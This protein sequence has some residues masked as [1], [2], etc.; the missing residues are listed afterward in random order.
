MKLAALIGLATSIG[1]A[2]AGDEL[3]VG[4]TSQAVINGT[5]ANNLYTGVGQLHGGGC[6]AVLVAPR[7]MLTSAHCLQDHALGCTTLAA[8]PMN[9]VFAQANGGWSGEAS[10]LART[11]AIEGFA[12]RP[13]LFDLG[14]CEVSDT[15]HCGPSLRENIDHSKELVVLY[16][17]DEAPADAVPLPIMVHPNVDTTHFA[18]EVGK[19]SGLPTWVDDNE[20]VV[21]TVGYGVGSHAY[22]VDG[23][24]VRGRD[25][26][27]QRW[28]A[29]ST[30]FA[31]YLGASDCNS[32]QPWST[33][34]GVVVAPDDLSP[35]QVG[36]A[37]LVAAGA[38]FAG[39]DF[40]HSGG[41]DSGGPILVGKGSASNGVSPTALPPPSASSSYD[42]NRSYIAGTASLWVGTATE[43]RT[44]FTPT[45]TLAAGTFLKQ[46]LH[47][48]D[49]D[50][51]ADAVDDDTDN[52]G[53]DDDADQH[54]SDRWVPIG[55]VHHL[56]CRPHSS[57]WLGDEG[58]DSDGDGLLN[59]ED[60]NDDNDAFLDGP[61]DCPVHTSGLCYRVGETCP[62]EPLFFDCRLG[63]C[64][65]LLVRISSVINPDP[66]RTWSY[67]VRSIDARTIVV[68]APRELAIDTAAKIFTGIG[69]RAPTGDLL[70]E[71][72]GSDGRARAT[73]ALYEPTRATI[74]RLSG[75]TSLELRFATDGKSLS[76]QGL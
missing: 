32:E 45:W 5:V 16:L 56:N 15:F 69:A 17:A 19:F 58:T 29:T 71:L 41:G 4:V 43:F 27:V 12:A 57:P 26:G 34:P 65:E 67:A 1:C 70:I 61:D 21:T 10:Y 33:E 49:Q 13:E 73:L 18:A 31:G 63:G 42:A 39:S 62:L 47:D 40:S 36:D 11:V 38:S 3:G 52:D 66:T 54:P 44:A 22:A 2:A 28:I 48:S 20:P 37:D 24:Q 9:V 53:C 30:S 74:G 51:Y 35:S 64:N 59:C 72:V 60:P 55:T 68:S 23:D 50:G 6:S 46:A 75:T 8:T 7:V 76:V 14:Q 25:Y